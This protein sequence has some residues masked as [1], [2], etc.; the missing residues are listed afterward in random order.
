MEN[1]LKGAIYIGFGIFIIFLVSDIILKLA[2][3]A[4]GLYFIY[5]GLQLRS[6]NNIL[7]HL[8]RFRNRF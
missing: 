7:F 5:K 3:V 1:S 8:H 4:S 6:A 2:V